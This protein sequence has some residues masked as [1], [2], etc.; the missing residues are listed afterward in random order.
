MNN[1]G[2]FK[3]KINIYKISKNMINYKT[4]CKNNLF[5]ITDI[6]ITAKNLN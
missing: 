4:K 3:K 5:G 2:R 6:Q 1:A